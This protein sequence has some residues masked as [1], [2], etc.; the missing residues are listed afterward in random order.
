MDSQLQPT[1][2]DCLSAGPIKKFADNVVLEEYS[3]I[4]AALTSYNRMHMSEKPCAPSMKSGDEELD[5]TILEAH[6]RIV[7]Y[8]KQHGFLTK[9][10]SQTF[11][12]IVKS[13][14]VSKPDGTDY[15]ND[16][17]ENSDDEE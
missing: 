14:I 10:N 9:S 15:E 8:W 12:E 16:D 4:D 1:F 7:G 6:D 3:T 13:C 11:L 2:K 5:Y 17:M